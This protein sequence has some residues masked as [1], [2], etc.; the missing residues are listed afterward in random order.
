MKIRKSVPDHG[1]TRN[2]TWDLLDGLDTEFMAYYNNQP[3]PQGPLR[4]K[5]PTNDPGTGLTSFDH[6]DDKLFRFFSLSRK[7]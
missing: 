6:T 3:R 4:E 5:L 1:G 7:F 2:I